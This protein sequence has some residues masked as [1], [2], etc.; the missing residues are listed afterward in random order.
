MHDLKGISTVAISNQTKQTDL[1]GRVRIARSFWDRG[2]GL[3]FHAGLDAGTGLVIDP[4]S[5]IHTMW[6]RFPLDVLYVSADG[7]V[8]RADSK[9]KPWRVGPLFVRGRYVIELPPGTIEQSRTEKGDKL[10]L[11]PVSP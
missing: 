5:S 1:G 4:C 2:R 3:M 9:M 8:L 10:D 7:S 11:R 6:M